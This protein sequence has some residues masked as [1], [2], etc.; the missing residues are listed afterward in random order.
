MML[1]RLQPKTQR[2]RGA[3]IMDRRVTLLFNA[4]NLILALRG[5]RHLLCHHH[6]TRKPKGRRKCIQKFED[7]YDLDLDSCHVKDWFPEDASRN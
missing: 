6:P 3:T 5:H 1:A 2:A 7:R 4:P